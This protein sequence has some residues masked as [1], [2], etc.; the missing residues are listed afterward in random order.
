MSCGVTDAQ[1]R[2]NGVVFTSPRRYHRDAK[3]YPSNLVRALAA[4]LDDP[5]PSTT[6]CVHWLE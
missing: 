4:L 1:Q 2:H 3:A 5:A 6:D